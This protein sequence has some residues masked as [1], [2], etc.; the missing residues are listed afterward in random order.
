MRRSLLG[1]SILAFA[2]AACGGSS[3]DPT[4]AG[5]SGGSGTGGSGTGG[6]GAGVPEVV[7]KTYIVLGD[8]ISDHGGDGPFFND[9]LVANDDGKYPEWKGKDLKSR[10]GQDLQ[11][12]HGAK[13]GAVS[14]DLPGQVS[15]LPTSLPGPIVVSIT[16]G[17]N[18]MSVN[19][20]KILQGTD[21][22]ARDAYRDNIAAALGE[23]TTPG[24]FGESVEVKVFETDIYDPTDGTGD[25]SSCPAPFSFLPKQPTDGFFG[26]WN[27]VSTDEVP[28]HG[29]S[30]SEPLHDTFHGHGVVN[31]ADT[32]F[33]G[34]CIHP[35]SAGHNQI[36]AMLWTAI[37][38]EA[39]P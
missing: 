4:G 27:A 39:A 6:S 36:R 32:W 23:L 31:M 8:S 12:V 9:L 20:A 37:T 14:A 18:D 34:D 17:G 21:Q 30:V 5:G 15:K 16:I 2:L 26:N 24:R 1:L 29:M 25:F 33:A 11:V 35:N 19:I 7:Y 10:F 38:G 22:G 28:K 13:G 3:G